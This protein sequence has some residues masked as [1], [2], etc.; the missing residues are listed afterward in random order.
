MEELYSLTP[1]L[2]VCYYI[3]HYQAMVCREFPIHLSEIFREDIP[4]LEVPKLRK[5]FQN[6]SK[7]LKEVDEDIIYLQER[8][9][10]PYLSG[11]LQGL[12]TDLLVKLENLSKLHANGKHFL[13]MVAYIKE[14]VSK[15]SKECF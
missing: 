3:M 11:D 10:Q 1:G 13:M 7:L 9:K 15:D 5:D 6:N 2:G 12:D 4:I 8:V 14:V